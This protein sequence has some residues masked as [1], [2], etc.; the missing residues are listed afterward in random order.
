MVLLPKREFQV[1]QK[2]RFRIQYEIF[3]IG[4]KEGQVILPAST[5]TQIVDRATD[6]PMES[7]TGD[8]L[9]WLNR[10]EENK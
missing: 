7:E 6:A 9:D 2:V 5:I 10:A 3:K 8:Y 1:K 4:E